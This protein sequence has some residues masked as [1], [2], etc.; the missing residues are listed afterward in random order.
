VAERTN[1]KALALDALRGAAEGAVTGT[2]G[3]PV[4]LMSLALRPLGYNVEK[5]VGGSEWIRDRMQGAGAYP[6]RTGSPGEAFGELAGNLLAPGPDPLQYAALGLGGMA[7]IKAY[8]G[9]PHT[10]D[11]FDMSK[12]GTG[13]GAQAYG[14]GLYFAENPEVAAQYK[15]NTLLRPVMP[16]GAQIKPTN[17]AESAAF[18]ALSDAMRSSPDDPF[19]AAKKLQF[20]HLNPR[21]QQSVQATLDQW[22]AQGV[23]A[24]APGATYTV[25]LDVNHDDLLDWDAPLSQQPEKV[26]KALEG[27]GVRQPYQVL[28]ADGKPTAKTY[29]ESAEAE[30]EAAKIGGAVRPKQNASLGYEIYLRNLGGGEFATATLREAGIP[31][32]RYL[33]GG[34]RGAGDGT[35]NFVLFDDALAQILERNGQPVKP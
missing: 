24:N 12:L 2:L 19:G 16:D 6:A 25:N 33:D 8:H 22:K 18:S 11:R 31:G 23:R 15:A 1:W 26:R 13:E 10:F 30:A 14:H 4:D 21:E 5:P 32:I 7:A 29:M 17:D 9:S 3:A 20:F 28:D 34:S 35:R 27:L